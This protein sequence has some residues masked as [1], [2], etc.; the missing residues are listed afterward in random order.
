MY[1]FWAIFFC[2]S[3]IIDFWNTMVY[4]INFD[5][6]YLDTKP[7]PIVLNIFKILYTQKGIK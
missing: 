2:P 4:S 6:F 5:I 3:Y 1:D 7:A